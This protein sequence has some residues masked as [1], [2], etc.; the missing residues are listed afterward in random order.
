MFYNSLQFFLMK[1]IRMTYSIACKVEQKLISEAAKMTKNWLWSLSRL[2]GPI[3]IVL[4]LLT[5]ATHCFQR[6]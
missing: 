4:C 5:Q 2:Q 6:V 3:P 1:I